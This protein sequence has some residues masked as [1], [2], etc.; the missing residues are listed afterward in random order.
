MEW[1]FEFLDGLDSDGVKA[2]ML[3]RLA[4]GL[5]L[6]EHELRNLNAT[7]AASRT[8]ARSG[9]QAGGR[10]SGKAQ[11]LSAEAKK[12][13]QVLEFAIRC[14]G[15][16]PELERIGVFETLAT[17]RAR[18]FWRLLAQ[19]GQYDV[20][21]Y[22]D[23]RQKS[24]WGQCASKEPLSEEEAKGWWEDITAHASRERADGRKRE[25]IEAMRVAQDAGD[26]AEVTRLSQ[27]LSE[28]VGRNQ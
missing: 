26:S 2:A 6:G 16:I 18:A 17:D 14:P 27:A 3:T 5:G 10:A 8:D 22:L 20:L 11:P 15:Y 9:P 25:L 28:L 12:D 19:F 1:A 13:A 7:R 23:E 21:P 24:F 4:H